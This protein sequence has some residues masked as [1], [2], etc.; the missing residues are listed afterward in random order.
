MVILYVRFS[1][2]FYGVLV[3]LRGAGARARFSF[4]FYLFATARHTVSA[5]YGFSLVG[6]S[7]L[8]NTSYVYL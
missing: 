5:V 2:R 3:R 1:A 7:P 8:I 4:P 6:R